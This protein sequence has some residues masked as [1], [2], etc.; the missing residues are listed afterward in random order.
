MIDKLSI[1]VQAFARWMLTSLLV[2]EIL[3]L[4]YVNLSTCFRGL[5][6][7]VEITASPS[8]F[9]KSRWRLGLPWLSFAIHSYHPLLL[10]CLLGCI[11]NPQSW[12]VWDF[13]GQPILTHP[14][15]RVHKRTLLMSSSLL[16]QQC[17]ASLVH[18]IWIVCDMRGK[19]P[20]SCC[21]VKC[22]FQDLFKTAR[23]I[24]V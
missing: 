1:A 19:W 24:L 7:K 4:R 5:P 11:L 8:K 13:S 9:I 3:L 18:L 20:Y 10:P 2:E 23:S 15:A 22:C 12:C 6:L 14:C 17:A 16:L 21:F